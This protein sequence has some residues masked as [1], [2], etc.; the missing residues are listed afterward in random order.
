MR[1]KE[2]HEKLIKMAREKYNKMVKV[3]MEDN[4]SSIKRAERIKEAKK[5][6]EE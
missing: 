3:K 6:Y 4:S 1:E 2:E 5:R